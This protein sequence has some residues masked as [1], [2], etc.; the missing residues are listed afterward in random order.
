MTET[1]PP[2]P[3][4]KADHATAPYWDAAREHRLLLQRCDR[5]RAWVHYPRNVC[6]FCLAT[7]LTFVQARGTGTL[8]S[9]TVTH[10]PPPA[11]AGTEPYIVAL[12]DLD[13]GVRLVTRIVDCEPD[14]VSIGAR[15]SVAFLDVGDVTLPV[16]RLHEHDGTQ[17]RKPV[18]RPAGS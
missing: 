12:V 3:I 5:C 8:Y 17:P 4:P 2:R 1:P 13:E 16:F 9:F 10:R 18:A 11:F 7:E 14:A 15:V 6:P